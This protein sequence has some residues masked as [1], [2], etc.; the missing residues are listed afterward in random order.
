MTFTERPKVDERK[1]AKYDWAR[2]SFAQEQS[3]TSA[4]VTGAAATGPKLIM[5][6]DSDDDSDSPHPPG[7]V[8][9][10]V[11]ETEESES[12]GESTSQEDEED[13]EARNHECEDNLVEGQGE[14]RASLPRAEEEIEQEGQDGRRESEVCFDIHVAINVQLYLVE[15]SIVYSLSLKFCHSLTI[16]YIS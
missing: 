16:K 3:N 14:S 15:C 5:D 10:V 8:A 13:Y 2:T 9:I 11:E 4:F 1:M 12:S 7:E 6:C